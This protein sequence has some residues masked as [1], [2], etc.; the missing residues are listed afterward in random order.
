MAEPQIEYTLSLDVNIRNIG[1]SDTG[2][3]VAGMYEEGYIIIHDG[4]VLKRRGRVTKVCMIKSK[5]IVGVSAKNHLYFYNYNGTLIWR[6]IFDIEIQDF[7]FVGL[8]GIV[9]LSSGELKGINNYKNVIWSQ[10]Y[11]GDSNGCLLDRSGK[12]FIVIG[13]KGLDYGLFANGTRQWSMEFM[14]EIK[15]IALS[16]NGSKVAVLLST[17][18]LYL[19][20]RAGR[21]VLDYK[22]A[23]AHK[24]MF[25]STG[26]LVV[27]RNGHVDIMNDQGTLL[28]SHRIDA[29]CIAGAV[30]DY[31][32]QLVCI[33]SKKT[34][35]LIDNMRV[36]WKYVVDASIEAVD[37]TTQGEY[38]VVGGKDIMFFNNLKYYISNLKEVRDKVSK[39]PK[40]YTNKKKMLDLYE[41]MKMAYLKRKFD[42]FFNLKALFDNMYPETKEQLYY[43][44]ILDDTFSKTRVSKL[45]LYVKDGLNVNAKVY[46]NVRYLVKRVGMKHGIYKYIISLKPV[47]EGAQKLKI[48]IESPQGTAQIPFTIYADGTKRNRKV[49][50]NTDYRKLIKVYSQ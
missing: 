2:D 20:N 49:L 13:K 44:L 31:A 8:N 28:R 45:L 15:D 41:K 16:R 9:L 24:I 6:D 37:V 3:L 47:G 43:A 46:G 22:I 25:N 32:G 14:E 23:D 7:S 21:R 12:Y 27:F 18:D 1:V 10:R 50:S 4:Y 33:T 42:V 5:N 48:K 38:I 11:R 40:S 35:H 34:V 26:N 36:I 29:P 19:I 17:G 39:L 30:T